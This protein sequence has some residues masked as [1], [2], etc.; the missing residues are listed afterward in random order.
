MPCGG[1]VYLFLSGPSTPSES[2]WGVQRFRRGSGLTGNNQSSLT[3]NRLSNIGTLSSPHSD[4]SMT[5]YSD[6]SR[7]PL[8][9]SGGVLPMKNLVD[10]RGSPGPVS[11]GTSSKSQRVFP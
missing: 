1:T 2:V 8:T 4:R 9:S 5:S 11:L 6:T 10:K 7:Y 3:N